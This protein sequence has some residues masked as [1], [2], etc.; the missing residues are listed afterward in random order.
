MGQSSV[1]LDLLIC[2]Y[3]F[4]DTDL[5]SKA[6]LNAADSNRWL[7]SKVAGDVI[8][9]QH[10]DSYQLPFTVQFPPPDHEEIL[11]FASDCLDHYVSE[12]PESARMPEFRIIE[13][14]NLIHYEPG[15]AYHASHS[16]FRPHAEDLRNRHLSFVMFLNTVVEGGELEF[17]QQEVK[18]APLARRAVIFPT[19]WTHAH[20]SLAAT[21]DR[22]IVQLWWSFVPEENGGS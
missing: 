9:K 22:H 8:S 13:P 17:V 7:E 16:D 10:R 11:A 21:A 18:V 6:I 5:C 4:E 20:R 19:Y 3:Q 14:Y 12:R 2:Q 15:Q 1:W